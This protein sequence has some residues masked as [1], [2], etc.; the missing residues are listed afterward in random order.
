MTVEDTQST[1]FNLRTTTEIK[2]MVRFKVYTKREILL[3]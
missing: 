2:T 3:M 1:G